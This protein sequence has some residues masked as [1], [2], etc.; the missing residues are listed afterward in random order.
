MP[1]RLRA[2][3]VLTVLATVVLTAG[4]GVASPSV[5]GAAPAA[6]EHL[7]PFVGAEGVTYDCGPDA[8]YGCTPGYTGFNVPPSMW[9]AYGCDNASGCPA[10][11]HNC[12]LWVAYMLEA[13]AGIV[14]GW[15][16]D[17]S[18]WDVQAD[19][20]G[21]PVNQTAA[22]GAI[23]QWN[24]A[25]KGHLA[26]VES[27]SAS[28]IT[29]TMDWWGSPETT[30]TTPGGYTAR[31]RIDRS[32]PSWPDNF[33]HYQLVS[34]KAEFTSSS[35]GNSLTIAFNDTSSGP[36][37]GWSWDFGDGA[38]SGDENPTHTF[39]GPGT[40]LVKLTVS[41]QFGSTDVAHPVTVTSSRGGYVL[42]GFGGLNR[43]RVG[44]N[45]AKPPVATGGAYWSGW[46]I[47]RGVA[48]L[49]TSTG[50]YTLDGFGGLHKFRIGSGANPPTPHGGGY[51][52][53]WDIAR[54]AALLPDGTGGYMVDGYGGVHPF[55]L[56]SNPMPP[57]IV[58]GPYWRGLDVARGIMLTPDGRGGFIVDYLGVLH[59]FKVGSGG[60]LPPAPRGIDVLRN[61]L[62]QGGA[63][64]SEG[65]GGYTVDGYGGTHPFALGSG[66]QPAKTAGPYWPRWNIARDIALVTG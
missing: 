32:S 38:T 25:P 57:A 44:T 4:L 65:T 60:S 37:T 40:Y 62:G 45:G 53:G 2:R 28:S 64:L 7:L 48:V 33:L 39:P 19:A 14:P 63:L 12:Y 47:A 41:N 31:I 22:V 50:G 1:T 16:A 35:G 3:A 55:R 10:T 20:S 29:L 26:L 36:V 51:W 27:V 61:A 66:P 54:G 5:A 34:T 18:D 9:T 30:P 15:T 8:N 17:A 49:P 58:G 56:G 46:D 21:V 24:T 6:T 59:P 52:V 11:P 23:A 43:F 13:T 42:D